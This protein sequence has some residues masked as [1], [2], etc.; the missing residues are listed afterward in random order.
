MSIKS[1]TIATTLLISVSKL[2]ITPV[3]SAECT[4]NCIEASP[5]YCAKDSTDRRCG[6]LRDASAVE[7]THVEP[8]LETTGAMINTSPFRVSVDG[9][10]VDANVPV[11]Q[12][13][14]MR[15]ADV[16]ASVIKIAPQVEKPSRTLIQADSLHVEPAL[17]V[18]ASRPYVAPGD[19]IRFY[20]FSNYARYIE[21]AEI[22]I[23]RANDSRDAA[24]YIRIPVKLGEAALWT[25]ALGQDGNYRFTMRVYAKTGRYDETLVQPLRV[26]RSKDGSDKDERTGPLLENNRIVGNIHVKGATV[27]VSG[28]DIP[29]GATVSVF[30]QNVPVTAD[31][32]FVAEQIVPE[33]MDKITY[34]IKATDGTETKIERPVEIK[35]ADHFL[36]A[37]GDVTAGHRSWNNEANAAALQG[38]NADTRSNY[39]D[40]RFAF[41]YKGKLNDQY[42]VTA[43]ADTGEQAFNHLFSQFNQKDPRSLLLR[44]DSTKHYPVYGDDSTTVEDAPTY[45]RFYVRVEDPN[46]QLLWGNFQTSLTD[47]ELMQFSRSLYGGKLDWKSDA[48]TRFG[49]RK[50]N[51]SGFAADPGTLGTREEFASTGGTLYYLRHQDITQGSE[52]VFVETRDRD[53]GLV[54]ERRELIPAQDYDVNYLQGRILLRQLV[55]I[56]AEAGQFV[57]NS[58][59]AGN[60]VYVVSTYEY[61]PGL[62]TPST[63]TLGGQGS[64]WIGDHIRVGGSA[65]HQGDDQSHQ[66]LYGGDVL[67]R[68][69]P[70]SYV[71]VELAKSKGADSGTTQSASGGYEFN[72]VQATGGNANAFAV[73]AAAD[74]SEFSHGHGHVGGYWRKRE[75]GFSGP[76]VLTGG[77]DIEQTG[78]TADL[79][80][81]ANTALIGKADFTNSSLASNHAIEAGITHDFTGGFFAK[82]GVRNDKRSGLAGTQSLL[83]NETGTRTD[84]AITLGYRSH[85]HVPVRGTPASLAEAERVKATVP[86]VP[87]AG[88]GV[89]SRPWSLYFT[90]QSS[91]MT[92][93]GRSNNS[94]YGGGGDIQLDQRT[95][96]SAEVT[97]GDRGVGANIGAEYAFSDRGSLNL[98]YALAA[99]SPDSFNTGR[100]GRVSATSR[101]R[102]TDAISVFGE[103]R[104]DHGTGPSG[105]TQAYGVDFAPS[106]TWR[107]GIRYEHGALSDPASGDIVRSTYGTNIDYTDA[108]WRWSSSMEHRTD[109][110]SLLGNRST[111]ATRNSVSYKPNDDWRMYGKINL[112]TSSGQK[113]DAL[114]ANYYE[115][116]AATAYRPVKNDRLNLLAKYTFLYDLASAGQLSASGQSINYAQRSHVFAIDATYQLNR[117]LAV[118]GKYA[119]RV[120]QLR[121]ARD[122]SAQWF[123]STAQFF[124]VRADVRVVKEWDALAELR[125]LSVS[126]AQDARLGALVGVYRHF[127]KNLKV[128][129]GYN[130]TNYS[131]DLTN[132]N[133]NQNG[134]FFNVIAKY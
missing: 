40:G 4:F 71:K 86:P 104:Y 110:S 128:G 127:G 119:Y 48:V 20:N 13:D 30:G 91:L 55:P 96:V 6:P 36:V 102:F 60:P 124:A 89:R 38:D 85:G 113:S 21:S 63:L 114:S 94:R 92:D 79:A 77:Q 101:Y 133:Y 120:G 14:V 121:D 115:A 80:L 118:G 8:N 54:L 28:S 53:S 47:N 15:Q 7:T 69:K 95:R 107:F 39:V 24:P 12:A 57:R 66:T 18:V 26:T 125:R 83:L 5:A 25:P 103:G 129:V 117:Y 99:E 52:R 82:A 34:V 78:A 88:E 50:T 62:T 37:I 41:Y 73:E 45:G 58:S 64:Q 111:W 19:T 33:G 32:K 35:R 106:K 72:Q 134:V 31:G 27:T 90:G 112:A 49:E 11:Q 65:Y 22:L 10:P 1:L 67:L 17:S 122:S 131:D 23:Y 98:S 75:A 61:S 97:D 109:D 42:K 68:Y 116:V 51:V 3:F 84:G 81:G 132:L 123:L 108:Q 44:L 87:K 59:F 46:S 74:L 43:S 9:V 56:T 126:Q 105:L 93:A 29:P 16:A 130:F 70:G 2:A 76:G 100:L